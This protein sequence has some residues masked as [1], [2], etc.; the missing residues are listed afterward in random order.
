MAAAQDLSILIVGDHAVEVFAHQP[1][2]VDAHHVAQ[3]EGAGLG[4]PNQGTGE[5]VHFFDGVAVLDGEFHQIALDDAEH[6]V[7]HEVGRVFGN[8]DAFAQPRLGEGLHALHQ[9]RVGLRRGDN[10][11]Q[12]QVAG[13]VEEVCAHEAALEIGAAPLADHV[14]RN[15]RRVAADQRMR[16]DN[17]L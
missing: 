7:G 3:A 4:P 2:H 6:A 17:R 16:G 8:D 13:R 12:V 10:F 5:P 15:A 14:H 9:R 11:E 1:H